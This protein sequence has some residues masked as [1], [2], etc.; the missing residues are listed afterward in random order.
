MVVFPLLNLGAFIVLTMQIW[1][2]GKFPGYA[3]ST[4]EKEPK[5]TPTSPRQALSSPRQQWH[6]ST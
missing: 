6:Q 4:S 2:A 1:T 3:I 5:E